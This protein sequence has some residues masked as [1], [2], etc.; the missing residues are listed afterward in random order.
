VWYNTGVV[1][2]LVE[3]PIGDEPPRRA[4][5]AGH[6]AFGDEPADLEPNTGSNNEQ[7]TDPSDG[8]NIGTDDDLWDG[9]DDDMGEWLRALVWT[10]GPVAPAI[11]I[12][13]PRQVHLTGE[14]GGIADGPCRV[15]TRERAA[16]AVV[17]RPSPLRND[18]GLVWVP[19]TTG[20]AAAVVPAGEERTVI[21]SLFV[22]ADLPTG[23]YAGTLDTLATLGADIA[24]EVDIRDDR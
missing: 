18:E 14:P 21:V 9:T 15:V 17:L 16:A 3:G 23:R 10:L 24:L 12:G 1:I 19:V 5:P 2:R 4:R 7:S 13:S 11:C 20:P 8:S 6:R 22:P